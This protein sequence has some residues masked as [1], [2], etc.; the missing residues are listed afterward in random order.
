M[1][2]V[3]RWLISVRVVP[4]NLLRISQIQ[5]K[6]HNDILEPPQHAFLLRWYFCS[7]SRKWSLGEYSTLDLSDMA[8]RSSQY[9]SVWTSSGKCS[10]TFRSIIAERLIL[11]RASARSFTQTIFHSELNVTNASNP[12]LQL[13]AL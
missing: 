5:N 3:Q 10:Q 4:Q 12:W 2:S 11:M 1:I 9:A 7:P 6:S 8:R 13:M